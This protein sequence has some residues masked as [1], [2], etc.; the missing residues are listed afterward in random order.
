MEIEVV[1]RE[2]NELMERETVELRISHSGEATPAENAVRKQ[3]AAELDLDPLTIR[4][5]HIYSSQGTPVSAGILTVFDDPIM[6]E[7]PADEPDEEATEEAADEGG[8]EPAEETEEAEEEAEED[9]DEEDAGTEEEDEDDA[10]T[11]DDAEEDSGEDAETDADDEE[12][13]EE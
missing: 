12:E 8:E 4:V 9:V 7:L 10:D 13:T 11:E 3:V 2:R 6:D 5:D 1:D